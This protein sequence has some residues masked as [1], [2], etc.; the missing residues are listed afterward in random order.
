M[1][2]HDVLTGLP[3]RLLLGEYMPQAL[4][5]S[6]RNGG[7]AVL[8]LNLDRFKVINDTLGHAAG[9]TL[10]RALSQRL[11]DCTREMDL[12]VRLGGNEFAIVQEAVEQ[13]SEATALARRLVK[14]MARPFD[15]AGTEVVIGTSVGIAL[16]QDGLTTPEALLKC[17]DLALCRAKE[18]GRGRFCF[19]EP[20]M[21]VRVQARRMLEL[22][23]R[24]ALAL[25]Q[26]EVFYQPLVR[27]KTGAISGFEA[28][29]RWRHPHRGLVSPAIFI[30]V[31]EEIGL[32]TAIGAWV[33]ARA[34]ADAATWPNGLKVAVN[35]PP[36]QFRGHG[37]VDEVA[38][39]L[40]A[41]GLPGNRLELEI[42]ESTLIQDDASVLAT[43]H[44]LRA[45]G[46]R[47]AMDDFGTGY[48]S[49]S[50]LRRFPFDKIKIDQSFV[51]GM[52]DQADCLAIVRAVIGLG[53]SLGIAVNA[54]GVETLEQLDALRRGECGELQGFLFS[55]PRPSGEVANMLL[56]AFVYQ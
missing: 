27:T 6:R 8:C 19:F 25:G 12:I 9:D 45:L 22:D 56:D 1:A 2:R 28:L 38:N 34:C 10:L 54:E 46:V 55:R 31:V 44:A 35:L 17:A 7:L 53:R 41:S 29:L 48:S 47:I 40:T 18:D 14:E 42:T 21:D 37:L 24:S 11:K 5:R 49:L 51:R 33:L 13:P 43:L 39:A 4:A 52:I 15:I 32:I 30:P 50:Y 26:F 20:E 16:A 36:E 23:L 3:N